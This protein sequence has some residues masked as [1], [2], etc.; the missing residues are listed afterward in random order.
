[1]LFISTNLLSFIGYLAKRN[2][3]NE[4]NIQ[5]A[6]GITA[7]LGREALRVLP[8]SFCGALRKSE[9]TPFIGCS[10]W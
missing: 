1:M 3:R 8:R 5:G 2:E 4:R 10:E 9:L 6:E 7:A